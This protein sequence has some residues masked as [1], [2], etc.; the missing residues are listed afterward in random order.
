ML[1][2]GVDEF[3]QVFIYRH[4]EEWVNMRR[5]AVLLVCVF[6]LALAGCSG[7][8]DRGPQS[9]VTPVNPPT[10]TTTDAPPVEDPVTT[11]Q[12][13]VTF[14]GVELPPGTDEGGIVDRQ[15]LLDANMRQ[16]H[17]TD[18]TLI[19]NETEQIWISGK[20]TYRSESNASYVVST[21]GVARYTHRET[22]LEADARESWTREGYVANGTRYSLVD[23]EYHTSNWH[24]FE[25]RQSMATLPLRTKVL[26][27]SRWQPA[28]TTTVSGVEAIVFTHEPTDSASP[29]VEMIVDARGLI[30]ELRYRSESG[31]VDRRQRQVVFTYDLDPVA[32]IDI[33]PP[34]WLEEA[35]SATRNEG[36][37]TP[38]TPDE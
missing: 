14:Q 24:A 21:E 18:V 15:R 8:S 12:P 31:Q 35:R 26:I 16:L 19:V 9:T 5:V 38:T 33:E 34:A 23:G 32:D 6:G 1:G 27:S 3:E 22:R 11:P 20:H 2:T 37:P 7:P 13:D 10:F 30:H 4:F 29:S 25:V 28:R 36:T 17:Q